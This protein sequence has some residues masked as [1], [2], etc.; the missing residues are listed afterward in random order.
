MFAMTNSEILKMSKVIGKCPRALGEAL[1]AIP[2]SALQTFL[3]VYSVEAEKYQK[4]SK[5]AGRPESATEWVNRN[6]G[7]VTKWGD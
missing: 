6:I 5:E 3:S 1:K 4:A 2:E 7:N